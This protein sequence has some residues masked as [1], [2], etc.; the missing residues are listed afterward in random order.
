MKRSKLADQYMQLKATQA[1]LAAQE[2]RLKQQLLALGDTEIEGK[3]ARVTLSKVA[4]RLSYDSALLKELVPAA[5]LAQC[6][7]QGKS[8]IRFGVKARTVA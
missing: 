2:E 7:K 3:L 6:E 8:S 4:G 5:T 1:D